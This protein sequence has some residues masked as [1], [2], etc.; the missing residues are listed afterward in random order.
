MSLLL[1]NSTKYYIITKKIGGAGTRQFSNAAQVY[2]L[3]TIYTK[4]PKTWFQVQSSHFNFPMR[5]R[6]V[7]STPPVLNHHIGNPTLDH[8]LGVQHTTT[9]SLGHLLDS[10]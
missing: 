2:N 1:Y 10:L 5:H 7:N 8:T 9:R 6:V 4:L 3:C